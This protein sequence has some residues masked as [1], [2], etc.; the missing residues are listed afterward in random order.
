[1][2]G[3]NTT[4]DTIFLVVGAVLILLMGLRVSRRRSEKKPVEGQRAA[5]IG[6][7]IWFGLM[8]VAL[9]MIFD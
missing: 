8:G 3:D 7:L 5:T 2:D 4:V 9:Y 1:M 6:I